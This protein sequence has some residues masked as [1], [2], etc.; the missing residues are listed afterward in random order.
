MSSKH[1][2]QAVKYRQLAQEGRLLEG[3]TPLSALER[4]AGFIASSDGEVS[5]SLR[6]KKR[7]RDGRVLVKGSVN[8]NLTMICQYCLEPVSQAVA[9]TISLVVVQSEEEADQLDSGEEALI[10]AGEELDPVAAI[11][12]DLILALPM[13]ARHGD[14]NGS[15]AC[16][17]QLGYEKPAID[18]GQ[19]KPNPFAVLAKLKHPDLDN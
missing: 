18:P 14:E 6:F 19:D 16:M 1:I 5:Y 17:E 7:R 12:D 4:L 2:P 11:E 8:T 3:S 9:A 13:I 15:S 10:V